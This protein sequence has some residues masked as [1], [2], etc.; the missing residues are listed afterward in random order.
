MLHP[1]NILPTLCPVVEVGITP[2]T[3]FT[4]LNMHVSGL[5]ED[6][7]PTHTKSTDAALTVAAVTTLKGVFDRI[8][9]MS[10]DLCM[11]LIL[12]FAD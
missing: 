11:H 6:T 10:V 8:K 9:S 7:K 12:G 1:S 3:L 4:L 2:W 5:C